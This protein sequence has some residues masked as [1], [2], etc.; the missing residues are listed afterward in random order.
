MM[1]YQ[2][3]TFCPFLCCAHEG[4]ERRLTGE[5]RRRASKAGMLISQFCEKPDC[6][7]NNTERKDAHTRSM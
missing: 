1:C 2:D 6:Y 5:I 7:T 4:C 3:R